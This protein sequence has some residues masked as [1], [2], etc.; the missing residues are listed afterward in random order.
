MEV[1]LIEKETLDCLL[2]EHGLL[3]D[4]VITLAA[5]LRK[6]QPDELMSAAEVCEFLNIGITTLQ[7]L[8]NSGKIGFVR[9]DNNRVGYPYS[10]VIGYMERNG[11][12]TNSFANG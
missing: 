3:C 6:K 10:E 2:D 7:T 4:M 11:V 12:P 8:R 5:R 9:E 1:L